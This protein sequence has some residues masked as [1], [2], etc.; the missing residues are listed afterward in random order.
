M[1]PQ[2]TIPF[3]LLFLVLWMAFGLAFQTERRA[4]FPITEVELENGLH[5]ILS[6]DYRLPLV[7]VTL[8]YGV[9][10]IHERPGQAGLAYLLENL[11]F[12]G[13]RNIGRMQ[14]IN[15]IQRTGG[16]LNAATYEDR[17]IFS[18]TVPS[19][20]LG[21]VLWLESDRMKS[22]AITPT[23]IQY[24]KAALIDEIQKR[25]AEDLYLDS[26]L[27]FDQLL[28]PEFAYHHP[29]F[30][31]EP[32]LANLTAED[33][34]DFY[35]TYYTPN[36]AVLSI[37]GNIQEKAAIE[38]VRKYFETITPGKDIRPLEFPKP[39]NIQGRTETLKDSLASSP[40]FRLGHVIAAPYTEDYY[41]LAIIEYILLRGESSRLHK[42]LIKKERIAYQLSG[43]IDVRR[44]RAAFKVFVIHNTETLRERNQNAIISEITKLRTGPVPE[45]ELFRAKNMFKTDY[46]NQYS[47]Y[48]DRAIY[49]AETHL[50]RKSL[51]SLP[52]ELDRYLGVTASSIVGVANR[53]LGRNRFL[54]NIKI[55]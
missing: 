8:A 16:Q 38:L 44:D 27:V 5:V 11:M 29:V 46:I 48:S 32:D 4:P 25:R 14:H 39:E 54:L 19:N 55:K 23:T 52:S 40:G 41:P 49:L 3:I 12:Q 36:N 10:S 9:G 34:K 1:R 51:R 7:A 35:A 20:Q 17:S 37:V 50:S 21:L 15:F 43:G 28:F 33:V 6:E 30:G 45:D 31:T 42:R 24:V 47:T 26:A 2:K 18:Q 22:L 53:Y 13:S